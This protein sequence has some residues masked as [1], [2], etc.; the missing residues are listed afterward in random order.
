MIRI[1]T[2]S[3]SD[4]TLEEAQKKNI[5]VVPLKIMFG[6][7]SYYDGI[8]ISRETFYE[9]LVSSEELPTTSQPSPEDFLKHFEDAKEA[10]DTVIAIILSS[11]ISGTFQS[12][13]IAKGLADYDDIHV[14]DS[15][16]AIA[17]LRL[18]VDEAVRLRDAGASATAII[19]R[20]N[21]IIPRITLIAMVDTLDYLYKGGRLSKA[22]KIAGSI[23]N[24]KPLITLANGELSLIG[25]ARGTKKAMQLIGDEMD[26]FSP[27][28]SSVPVYFGY[29]AVQS[30]C[31]TLQNIMYDR[32]GIDSANAYAIGASIGTH[33]GPN[34]CAIVYVRQ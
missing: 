26:K 10:G 31:Q 19:E 30:T 22:A 1:I 14:V 4:I 34:A 21:D 15:T 20:V 8:T 13:V 24:F 11:K 27:L 17:G 9:M 32:Y 18:L 33:V 7:Q 3:T 5:S 6:E 16:T 12:A 29:T 2:D 23:L 28:D 25:K